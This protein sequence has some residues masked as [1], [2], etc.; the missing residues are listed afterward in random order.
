MGAL[1]SVWQRSFPVFTVERGEGAYLY[2]SDGRRL[3]D[4]T[5]GIGVANTGHCHPRVVQAIQQ[6]AARV[7][8]A[9]INICVHEPVLELGRRLREVTPAGLDTF[10]F[11]NSGAEAVEAAVKLARH[12]TGRAN[13]IVFQ[14]AFHGRTLGM[15]S[16]TTSKAIYRHGY[17]PLMAGVCVAPYPYAYRYGW[18]PEACSQWCLEE[19]QH[20]LHT[21]APASDTAA[22][23]VEP[24]L[25]EGGYVVSPPS[26]LPGLRRICDQHGILLLIDEVQTG[27]GRTGRMFA[28]EHTGARPDILLMAKGL[29]SGM[30]LSAIAAP[31]ALMDRW[32]GGTHGGTYGGNA[33]ATAAA[34][35]TLAVLQEERLVENAAQQGAYLLERLK[36]L[37]AE[38]PAVGDVRGLGLMIGVEFSHGDRQPFPEAAGAVQKACL[39][40][41]LLL[42]TC[43][44]YGN[45]VRWIPPLVATREQVDQ[46]L[47]TFSRALAQIG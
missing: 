26:F 36:G 46:A 38:H 1:S 8:H 37:A 2:T 27:F 19:L 41:N 12:A 6:Q 21:V 28:L 32:M 11:S 3:L 31:R 14:G 29:A 25:G 13:I 10:F 39:Q 4:F 44:T 9:Q 42:L 30:P 7:I 15:T 35:A 16:L 20:L 5:S 43:G 17:Q 33:V 23:L 34:V 45:V 18:E 22:V 47:A 24:V 40:E